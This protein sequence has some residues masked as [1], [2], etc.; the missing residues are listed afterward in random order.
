MIFFLLD[1]FVSTSWLPL[2]K[3]LGGE[4]FGDKRGWR[5]H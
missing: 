2:G 5:G 4:E 3:G 1:R